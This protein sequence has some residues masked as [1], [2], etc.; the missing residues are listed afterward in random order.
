MCKII[1][2]KYYTPYTVHVCA[3]LVICKCMNIRSNYVGT[4][5]QSEY[6]SLELSQATLLEWT[7]S[8]S[9]D[10]CVLHVANCTLSVLG[11][12]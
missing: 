10:W 4:N 7:R 12:W 8:K 3:C 1:C 2:V 9:V 5:Y 11:V 6:L